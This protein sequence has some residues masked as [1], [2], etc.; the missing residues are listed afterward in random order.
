MG[1]E[2]YRRALIA[3]IAAVYRTLE[4]WEAGDL[5]GRVTALGEITHHYDA[6]LS[7]GVAEFRDERGTDQGEDACDT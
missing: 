4:T 2:H 5:A 3:V 7:L 6:T 1:H